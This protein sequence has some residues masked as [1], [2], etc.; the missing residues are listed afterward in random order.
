MPLGVRR[1]GLKFFQKVWG[2][3]M[4]RILLSATALAALAMPSIGSAADLPR[5]MPPAQ[6]PAMVPVYNWTGFY[7]GGNVGYA[8]RSTDIT[9]N[10]A[11]ASWGVTNDRFMLGGQMGYNWQV[12]HF[13]FG[14]EGDFDWANGTKTTPVVVTGI[15]NLQGVV[16][17]NWVA[18][19]AARLG[20]AVDRWL[21][22]TKL[23][24]GWTRT[25]TSLRS[26][27][28]GVLATNDKTNSGWLVGL[29]LEY[30]FAQ[31]WTAKIEY[32]YLGL[33][34]TT[35]RLPVAANFVTV[36]HDLQT[37]KVGANYKF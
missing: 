1:S 36:S 22:Y 23:G 18:T 5:A 19:L 3:K 7:L 21:I 35:V 27:T 13:V 33:S 4:K 30:A 12:G 34:D 9:G 8:W 29:G 14:V 24:G 17:G 16:D 10:F 15:G 11:G 28:L 6:V 26:A 37:L 25:E 31:N 20:Y 32:N 2:F